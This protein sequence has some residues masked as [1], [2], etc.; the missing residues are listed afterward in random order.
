MIPLDGHRQWFRFHHLFAQILRVELERREPELVPEL[1][2]RAYDWHR[3][4]GTTEEAIYH[5]LAA[6]AFDDAG[7]L[8]LETWVYYANAGRT[9]TV[10][11]WVRAFPDEAL[12]RDRRVLAVKAWVCALQGQTEEMWRAVDRLRALGGLAEGPLPD[13]LASLE[14]SLS[15]LTAI[16]S[17]S[18]DVAAA[19]ANGSRAARLEGPGF[20]VVPGRHVGAGLGALLQRR[21][22]P[23]RAA[24]SRRPSGSARPPSSGSSP[25]PRSR[26]CR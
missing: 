26:S 11:D 24:A 9:A 21:A 15:L 3:A 4:S 7:R 2:R 23:G 17:G 18:G 20:A 12:E 13:G 6:K 16:F 5:A 19:L 14:S 25:P 1:H 22:R 10:L 8:M